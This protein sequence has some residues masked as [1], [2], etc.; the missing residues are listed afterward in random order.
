MP[1]E[2]PMSWRGRPKTFVACVVSTLVGGLVGVVA[3]MSTPPAGAAVPVITQQYNMASAAVP[4]GRTN[5]RNSLVYAVN[6]NGS[7][8]VSVNEMCHSDYLYFNATFQPMQSLMVFASL[9]ID[10]CPGTDDRFGNGVFLL[11]NWT[12][13]HTAAYLSNPGLNCGVGSVECRVMVCLKV[14]GMLGPFTGCSAHLANG[15]AWL[16]SYQASE[17]RSK[18]LNFA[19]TVNARG[20]LTRMLDYIWDR[21]QGSSFVFRPPFCPTNA[22]DHCLVEG[23]NRI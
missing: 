20:Q 7:W 21:D 14:Q 19:N 23:E 2:C 8:F 16:A 17:Y 12:N 15:N 3:P 1:G 4:Q 11:G 13:Q 22:S 18:A 6:S 10:A 5:A 9:D